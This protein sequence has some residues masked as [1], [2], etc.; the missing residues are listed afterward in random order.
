MHVLKSF[1]NAHLL[2]SVICGNRNPSIM[3]WATNIWILREL[4]LSN[5][6]VRVPVCIFS[7]ESNDLGGSSGSNA[8][9]LYSVQA[10]GPPTA[11]KSC[12]IERPNTNL[13]R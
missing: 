6:C 9:T 11:Y 1:S 5:K 3:T 13:S 10:Y 4:K 2:N 12:L 8:H 7:N